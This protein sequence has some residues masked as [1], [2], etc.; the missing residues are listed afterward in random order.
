M[1]TKIMILYDHCFLKV[2]VKVGFF[3]PKSKGTYV[4]VKWCGGCI[5]QQ[6][7]IVVIHYFI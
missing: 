5:E 3:I 2:T 4:K 1:Q 7:G 6:I